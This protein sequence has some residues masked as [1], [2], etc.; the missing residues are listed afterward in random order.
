M[1]PRY[2]PASRSAAR[3][4]SLTFSQR[5]CSASATPFDGGPVLLDLGSY[6]LMLLFGFFL[7]AAS[8]FSRAAG[9]VRGPLPQQ[10]LPCALLLPRLPFLFECCT[11]A[12]I[13]IALEAACKG[14]PCGEDHEFRAYVGKS[15]IRCAK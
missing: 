8:A 4:R 3:R 2:S 11:V 9:D 14:K 7:S 13:E 15:I 1:K 5:A 10:L 6:G 12:A